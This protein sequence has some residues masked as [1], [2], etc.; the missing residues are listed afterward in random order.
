MAICIST[1]GS[2]KLITQL[3]NGLF[4]SGLNWLSIITHVLEPKEFALPLLPGGA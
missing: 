4:G 3:G 2:T 1:A